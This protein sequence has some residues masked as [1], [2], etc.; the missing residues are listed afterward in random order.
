MVPRGQSREEQAAFLSFDHKSYL[1]LPAALVP[2]SRRS[3]AG[4]GLSDRQGHV[5]NPPPTPAAAAAA[6]ALSPSPTGAR[7]ARCGAC[8]CLTGC[9]VVGCICA[10]TCSWYWY[11]YSAVAAFSGESTATAACLVGSGFDLTLLQTVERNKP[12]CLLDGTKR[13]PD[14]RLLLLLLSRKRECKSSAW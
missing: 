12:T 8:C 2:S 14:R 1:F 4:G 10:Q 9:A 5:L 13:Q 7:K 11:E 3:V 6:A